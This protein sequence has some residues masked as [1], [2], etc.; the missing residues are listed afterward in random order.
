MKSGRTFLHQLPSMLLVRLDLIPKHHTQLTI[1]H[2]PCYVHLAL[3]LQLFYRLRC[4]L[5]ALLQRAHGQAATIA[6]L[7]LDLSEQSGFVANV[8][9]VLEINGY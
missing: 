2:R 4:L 6:S 9:V 1:F 8:E 7:S 3:L 5:P